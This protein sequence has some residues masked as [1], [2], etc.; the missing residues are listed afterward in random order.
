MSKSKGLGDEIKKFTDKIGLSK[1]VKLLFGEDCGCSE[2]QEKLN[3]LFPNF[4]NIRAF[5]KDEKEIYEQVMPQIDKTQR[6][7]KEDKYIL[8]GLYR[9][10]FNAEA[11]WSSCGSCNKK[12]LDNMRKVY[13]KSC[14]L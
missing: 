8:N 14:D 4:K 12:T 9:A 3:K 2:R 10:V 6:I 7:T 5:T 13:E 11:K 1:A